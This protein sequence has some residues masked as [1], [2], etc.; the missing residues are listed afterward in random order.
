MRRRNISRPQATKPSSCQRKTTVRLPLRSTRPLGVPGDG[1]GQHGGLD[2]GADARQLIGCVGVI[3]ARH[4]LLD[5]RSFV[6]IGCHIVGRS[7][8]SA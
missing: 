5:Q 7:R 2:V 4:V 8:R 1:A 3:D 6:E